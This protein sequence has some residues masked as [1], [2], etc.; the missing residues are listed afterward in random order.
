MTITTSKGK[1]FPVVFI[2]V[3]LRDGHRLVIDLPDSRPLSEVAAD[4]EGL[5]TVTKTNTKT[6]G[7]KEIYEGFT[8][9]VEV[10]RN[11]AAGTVRVTLEKEGA[12]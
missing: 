2:G 6:P 11:M 10:H 1:V 12:A 8:N 4:F 9:L 7:V 3:L 5:E